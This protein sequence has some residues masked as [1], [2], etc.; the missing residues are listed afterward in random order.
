MPEWRDLLFA[1]GSADRDREVASG[2]QHQAATLGAGLP[3]ART[4]GVRNRRG[5]WLWKRRGLRPR[6]KRY[7]FPTFP[8]PRRRRS[9][10]LRGP[11][12]QNHGAPTTETLMYTLSLALV[13]KVGPVS[14]SRTIGGSL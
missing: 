2:V 14:P 13:Q 8:Q 4:G 9:I 11:C 12:T 7:A 10:F 1:K 3:A 6:G 5:K